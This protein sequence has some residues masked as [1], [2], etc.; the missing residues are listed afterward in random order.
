M[1]D[2]ALY[3]RLKEIRSKLSSPFCSDKE[4]EALKKEKSKIIKELKGGS[5]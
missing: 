1:R 5:E 4:Q 3:A 2:R